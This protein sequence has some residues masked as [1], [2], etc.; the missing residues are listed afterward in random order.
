MI[1]E[2]DGKRFEVDRYDVATRGEWYLA[3]FSPHEGQLVFSQQR[4]SKRRAIFKQV[5][6]KHEFGG[7]VF[8]ETGEEREPEPD[9]WWTYGEGLLYAKYVFYNTSADLLPSGTTRLILK[10]IRLC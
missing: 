10:P 2:Q 8:E 1:I 6:T 4:H 9:E 3:E 5:P 7:I